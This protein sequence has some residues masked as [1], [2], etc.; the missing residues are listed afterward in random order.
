M[1][2]PRAIR[3]LAALRQLGLR[4]PSRTKASSLSL[5]AGSASRQRNSFPFALK[6]VPTGGQFSPHL[7][8]SA[9]RELVLL[10]RFFRGFASGQRR[11][12][13]SLPAR[14]F[15]E[16][17]VEIDPTGSQ[18]RRRAGRVLNQDLFPRA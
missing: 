2:P 7:R 5:L 14:Q 11:G 1:P 6:L 16:P 12:D 10:G 15:P 18:L 4:C 17:G 3:A 8:N 9:S 13:P